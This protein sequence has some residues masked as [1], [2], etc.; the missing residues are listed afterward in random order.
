M[1]DFKGV[2]DSFDLTAVQTE[3]IFTWTM[4]LTSQ[5]FIVSTGLSL[6]LE[7]KYA[8]N[9]FEWSL[10]MNNHFPDVISVY[11]EMGVNFVIPVSSCKVT[12]CIHLQYRLR[13]P[14]K[15][16]MTS[17]LKTMQRY[18]SYMLLLSYTNN[19]VMSIF[20]PNLSC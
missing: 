4:V 7:V 14:V 11:L 19:Y 5:L 15:S 13:R 16:S 6:F 1:S 2:N 8:L 17:V 9:S 10:L 18:I 20:C 12:Y 3:G